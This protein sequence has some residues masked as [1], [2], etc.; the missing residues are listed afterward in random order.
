MLSDDLFD[1]I[2]EIFDIMEYHEYS[3][4]L[5]KTIL[6]GLS[7]F[8]IVIHDLDTS[9]SKRYSERE[10]YHLM[11]NMYSLYHNEGIFLTSSST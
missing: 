1:A 5:K 4:K 2:Y 8:L 11:E 10:A 6:K 3:Q 9:D 7:Y